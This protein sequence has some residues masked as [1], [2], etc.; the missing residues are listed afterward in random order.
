VFNEGTEQVGGDVD[1]DAF[2]A[3]LTAHPGLAPPAGG[4]ITVVG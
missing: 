4:R 1:L 2:T 3:Y